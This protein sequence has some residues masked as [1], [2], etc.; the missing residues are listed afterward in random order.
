[1]VAAEIE[2]HQV[3]STAPVD[4]TG[5]ARV[6]GTAAIRDGFWS[7]KGFEIASAQSYAADPWRK[8]VYSVCPASRRRE[9]VGYEAAVRSVECL[10]MPCPCRCRRVGELLRLC[11]LFRSRMRRPCPLSPHRTLAARALRSAWRSA[12]PTGRVLHATQEMGF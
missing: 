12:P 9:T 8:C 7:G 2:A 6:E 11:R 4:E 10:P 5:Y 3:T 1:M